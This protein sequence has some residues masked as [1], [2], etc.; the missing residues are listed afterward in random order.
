VTGA[1]LVCSAAANAGARR[2]VYVSSAAVYGTKAPYLL[3]EDLATSPATVAG[4]QQLAGETYARAYGSAL[5]STVVRLFSIY[6]P[7]Q[8]EDAGVVARFLAEARAGRAPTIHGDGA[9][10]RDFL[11]LDDA[12]SGIVAALQVPGAANRTFNLA[13]GE[14]VAVRQVAALVSELA[15]IGVPPRFAPARP[16]DPRDVKA[17]IAAARSALG[18]RPQVKLRDGLASCLAPGKR[19][20]RGSGS[21]GLF[22]DRPP[23][24]AAPEGDDPIIEIVDPDLVSVADA[25]ADADPVRASAPASGEARR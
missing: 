23:S 25:D 4:A 5:S 24:W 11:H 18:F 19:F 12:V 2:L 3:H 14:P 6:G 21:F 20:A 7:D 13:T 22:G 15:R 16:G 10:T 1:F 9:Q 8:D 17:S